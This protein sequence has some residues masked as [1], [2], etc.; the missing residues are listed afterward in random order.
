MLQSFT[1]GLAGVLW[2]C[3]APASAVEWTVGAG[4]TAAP[5]DEGSDHYRG[6]PVV[7]SLAGCVAL[8]CDAR[9]AK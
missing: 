4:V 2:L 6:V 3:A 8:C 9:R 5:D 1:R 7:A